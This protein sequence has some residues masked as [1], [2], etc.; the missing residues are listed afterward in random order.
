MA[1]AVGVLRDPPSPHYSPPTVTVTAAPD[2][3]NPLPACAPSGTSAA[4]RMLLLLLLPH[5]RENTQLKQRIPVS[6][7]VRAKF[8]GDA[9]R[10]F[11]LLPPQQEANARCASPKMHIRGKETKRANYTT[12]ESVLFVNSCSAREWGIDP[13]TLPLPSALGSGCWLYGRGWDGSETAGA[14][15]EMH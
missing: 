14:L 5:Q 10:V 4:C 1:R 11:D 13:P 15:M 7:R 9:S 3:R 2:Y 12:C 8:P 6:R